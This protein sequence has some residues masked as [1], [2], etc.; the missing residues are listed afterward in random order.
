MANEDIV[1]S[2]IFYYDSENITESTLAFRTAIHFVA[3]PYL[4]D[5]EEAVR[6]I[7]GFDR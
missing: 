5:D 3:E 6:R 4:Q 1:A 2:G 7:W